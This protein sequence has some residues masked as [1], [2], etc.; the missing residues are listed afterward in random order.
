[1][2][3]HCFAIQVRFAARQKGKTTERI[4]TMTECNLFLTPLHIFHEHAASILKVVVLYFDRL[5]IL[6]LVGASWEI[7]GR[8]HHVLG[9]AKKLKDARICGKSKEIT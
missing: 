1:M 4:R 9:D 6:D 3:V 8:N 5:V 7:I 2:H